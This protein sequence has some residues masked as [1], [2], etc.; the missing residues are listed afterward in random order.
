VRDSVA[1]GYVCSD[2]TNVLV[3]DTFPLG[4]VVT[5]VTNPIHGTA[6]V[7]G[8]EIVYAPDGTHPN[9]T[10]T[11]TYSLCNLCAIC[12]TGTLTI[13]LSGYPCNVHH[14][15]V[16][17]DTIDLCRN[18]DT[19]I[20]VLANDHDPDGNAIHL[21]RP[22]TTGSH[23]TV[24]LD[25]V[26]NVFLYHPNANFVGVDTFSYTACDNGI[27]SLCNTGFVFVNVTLCLPPPIVV[28]TLIRD[29]TTACTPRTFCIDSIYQGAGYT[30]HFSG[31]CDSADHGI[32]V[33]STD[34][35]TG[36]YGTLCFQYTPNCD[37]VGG[38][39]PFVG[40]DTMCFIIC[41][42]GTNINCTNVKTIIT[43]L[44]P[45][46]VDSI[47]A[48][49]DAT[50]TCNAPDTIHV[51]RNDILAPSPGTTQTGTALHIT[52]AGAAAGLAASHGTVSFHAG[53]STIIYTPNT[54][55]I[56]LDTFNYTIAD[57][58]T[59][60]QFD[61]TQVYV[62][63]CVAPHPV[64]VDDCGDTTTYVNES[65]VINVLNNDILQPANDTAV[66]V[67][68]Q[69]AHGT[70]VVNP[71]HTITFTPD[72]GFFGHD[73]M[74][75]QVCEIVGPDTGCSIAVVCLNVVDSVPACFFPNGFS[76]NNDGYNDV[77]AFPCNSKF[78]NATLEVFNRWGDVVW[79]SGSAY[80]NNWD[81][82]NLQGKAVPDGTY[83]FV[84]KYN[85]GTGRSQARFVVVNR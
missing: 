53:D 69:P 9:T 24:T 52:A 32:V 4:S 25:S 37:T 31:F 23:G 85:D 38:G 42:T 21:S 73:S 56:G 46:K 28:D 19:V 70:A 7:S 40:N 44:P 60:Q 43:V 83:F 27:P 80:Q 41:N 3:N 26:N 81:G 34:T 63:V 49:L 18:N 74:A 15:I 79:E 75:Y 54:G 36:V 68:V 51:L 77:F 11:I 33:L 71:D 16:V 61:T 65:A 76:P 78:P 50:Y 66:A 8:N 45:A 84:Y 72:T 10:E 59:P 12:D 58:G 22:F 14:P 6:T 30:V 17:N 82:T 29:T 13:S 35:T 64:A 47:K 67:V 5:I 2:T 48:V 57:N 39:Q 55:Y 62:Y 1:Y 20:N